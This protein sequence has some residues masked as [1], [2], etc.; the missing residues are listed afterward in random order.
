MEQPGSDV[1]QVKDRM[2]KIVIT[3]PI[4]HSAY[5]AVAF[6]SCNT[7]LDRSWRKIVG[8]FM[9]QSSGPKPSINRDFEN[10]LMQALIDPACK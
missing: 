6:K 10:A 2:G 8:L 5:Q 7:T 1:I 4:V 9:V 3:T